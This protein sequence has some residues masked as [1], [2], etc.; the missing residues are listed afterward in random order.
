MGSILAL[1]LDE[2]SSVSLS[3]NY[4]ADVGVE[5]PLAT[6]I[7]L[8][9]FNIYELENIGTVEI[10]EETVR[11]AKVFTIINALNVKT[12]SLISNM[13][14]QIYTPSICSKSYFE[15]DKTAVISVAY[16]TKFTASDN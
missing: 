6:T 3:G 8:Q 2:S 16:G 9:K 14:G 13:F 10:K 5:N 1:K 4:F 12:L 11:G 15:S 7:K